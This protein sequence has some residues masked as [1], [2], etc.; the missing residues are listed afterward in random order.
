MG[1]ILTKFQILRNRVNSNAAAARNRDLLLDLVYPRRCPVCNRPV[2]RTDLGLLS[3]PHALFGEK[4]KRHFAWQ[5]K[6]DGFGIPKGISTD[7]A[8]RRPGDETP[9][10]TADIRPYI[11]P[12]CEGT[13]EKVADPVCLRCGSPVSDPG[14][15]VCRTCRQQDHVFYRGSCVFLFRA[16]QGPVYKMK[17]GT[18]PEYASYFGLKIA[19]KIMNDPLFRRADLIL[20]VPTSPDRAAKR[21]Y[22]VAVLLADAAAKEAGIP[23][24]QGV[25][26]RTRNTPLLRTVSAR[27]RAAVLKNAFTVHGFDVKSK[28]IMLVDDI[29]TTG[30]TMDACARVLY[31]AGAARVCFVTLAARGTTDDSSAESTADGPD[32]GL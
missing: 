26:V 23:M 29:Y 14:V 6:L 5:E 31:Q 8:F 17:N 32:V 12:S 28:L 22:D 9:V 16:V 24:R 3:L 20:P 19:E 1:K 15:S 18:C 11:C 2:L 10:F 25:L 7:P 30:A 13:F 4:E 27:E 21:G